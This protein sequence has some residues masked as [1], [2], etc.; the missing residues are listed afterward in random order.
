MNLWW[1][2]P[3]VLCALALTLALVAAILA[4]RQALQRTARLLAALE[5]ELEP[6]L[7]D[8]RG[9]TQEAKAATHEVRIS[10]IR[11]SAVIERAHQVTE[12]LGGLVTGLWGLTRAGQ[13]VGIAAGIRKGI[14]VFVQRL[15]TPRGGKHD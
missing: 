11:L 8:L 3:L 5:Q 2:V 9:L 4:L 6:T 14:D 10:V 1:Q 15:A 7:G 13:I 12:G